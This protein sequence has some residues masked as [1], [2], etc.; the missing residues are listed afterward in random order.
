MGKRKKSKGKKGQRPQPAQ[1]YLCGQICPVPTIDHVPAWCLAPDAPQ[2]QFIQLPACE[3][4]NNLYQ[5]QESR[6]RDYVANVAM[7]TASANAAYQKFQRRTQREKERLGRPNRDLQRILD[8]SGT[9]LHYT[10]DG[11]FL[12]TSLLIRRAPD[13]YVNETFIKIARGIHYHHTKKVLPPGHQVY[14]YPIHQFQFSEYVRTAPY[15]YYGKQ[16][17]FFEYIGGYE[18][19]NPLCGV[20]AIS[21]YE[22]VGAVISFETEKRSNH[23]L[24]SLLDIEHPGPHFY[25]AVR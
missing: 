7:N 23:I 11:Q 16:K 5:L 8:N 2:S 4:C 15:L 24:R 1:C 14:I 9:A 18:Q 13:F 25:E 22:K 3:Q 17:D 12:G 21:I 20:W 19:N 10:M 6:F